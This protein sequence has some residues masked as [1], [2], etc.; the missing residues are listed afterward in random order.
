LLQKLLRQ[1]IYVDRV[2]MLS[3]PNRD[4][5]HDDILPLNQVDDAV[6]LADGAN[7]AESS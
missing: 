4:H 3:A 2:A 1:R 7:T 6:L 5:H